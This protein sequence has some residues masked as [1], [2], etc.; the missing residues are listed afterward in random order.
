[1]KI[2]P[3]LIGCGVA[4]IAL[5]AFFLWRG[6]TAKT[7]VAQTPAPSR[8]EQGL[9]DDL[10]LANRMLA[11][12]ELGFLDAY[13]HVSIRSRSNPNHFFISR[14]VSPGIVTADDIIEN[15]LDSHPV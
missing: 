7:A 9:L 8:S 1:M 2:R 13:G 14:Y 10:V 3:F 11:S 15:D 12:Q 4:E 6:G 5:M